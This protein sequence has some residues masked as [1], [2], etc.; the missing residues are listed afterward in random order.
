M[1]DDYFRVAEEVFV[2]LG[3]HPWKWE[4]WPWRDDPQ[5][6]EVNLLAAFSLHATEATP[7]LV[8][9]RCR[10]SLVVT[11]LLGEPDDSWRVEDAVKRFEAI[12]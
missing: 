4:G 10:V 7:K 6:V 11:R 12:T 8:L 5:R 1:D 3:Y 9:E 2:L